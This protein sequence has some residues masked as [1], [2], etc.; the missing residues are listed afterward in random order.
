MKLETILNAARNSML[1]GKRQPH[2]FS[3]HVHGEGYVGNENDAGYKEQ[4]GRAVQSE[5]D[6]IG[7]SSGYAELGYTDPAK[8]ILFADWNKFPRNFDRILEKAGYECEWQDEWSTCAECNKAVRTSPD[9][10]SWTSHYRILNECELVCLDCL[11]AAD[12]LKRIEDDP[13][14]CCP[15]GKKFDP[16]LHG[17]T[18][19][20]GKFETGFHPHQTDDP[21]AILKLLHA[22]GK[23]HV[24]FQLAD[25][26]QFDVTWKAFYKDSAAPLE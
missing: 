13:K 18:Q 21:K 10:Y 15:P 22:E 11:D 23:R 20:N 9:S 3:S 6:N 24:V 4:L 7:F 25:K 14:S 2:C 1:H 17:Y 26:G 12:Y 5:I 8:G 16:I 19:H